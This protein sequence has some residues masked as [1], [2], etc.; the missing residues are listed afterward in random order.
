MDA[1]SNLLLYPIM[2]NENSKDN[3]KGVRVAW[4]IT[5]LEQGSITGTCLQPDLNFVVWGIV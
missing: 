2:S 1:S 3:Q 4:I 5:T